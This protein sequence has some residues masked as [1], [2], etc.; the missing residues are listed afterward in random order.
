MF[1]KIGKVV[2]GGLA[3]VG[4]CCIAKS[5]LEMPFDETCCCCGDK[6]EAKDDKVMYERPSH[7][8]PNP[9]CM[10]AM[11]HSGTG[12][13]AVNV[14]RCWFAAGNFTADQFTE[15]KENLMKDVSV[16]T[17]DDAVLIARDNYA[18]GELTTEQYNGI[19]D[20]LKSH[21]KT[22]IKIE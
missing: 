10:T 20:E 17:T 8:E 16:D 2:V 13:R 4:A 5:I 6:S 21:K 18:Q 22:N 14:A 9:Y 7:V 12:D 11:E 1:R 19:M 3:L 15:V